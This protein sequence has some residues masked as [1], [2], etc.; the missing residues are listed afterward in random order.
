MGLETWYYCLQ[1]L[2]HMVVFDQAHSMG[3]I[4]TDALRSLLL[5]VVEDLQTI[6]ARHPDKISTFEQYVTDIKHD[7]ETAMKIL[8]ADDRIDSKILKHLEL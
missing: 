1:M 2:M 6:K 8:P 4:D 3:L 7:V 5:S